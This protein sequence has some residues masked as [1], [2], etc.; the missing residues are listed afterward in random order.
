MQQSRCQRNHLT[1]D[2]SGEL[3][4]SGAAGMDR[5]A[6]REDHEPSTV[7]A[8]RSADAQASLRVVRMGSARTGG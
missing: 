2:P 6:T 7:D 5:P 3:T 8:G 4:R 1:L